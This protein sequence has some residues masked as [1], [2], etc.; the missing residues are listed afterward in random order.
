MMSLYIIQGFV[1]SALIIAVPYLSRG[2]SK[3]DAVRGCSSQCVS[4]EHVSHAASQ[5]TH[6][7]KNVSDISFEMS[8]VVSE[9]CDIN[10]KGLSVCAHTHHVT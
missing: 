8:R 10:V 7:A 2:V 4:A 6:K 5:R 9:V 1:D 3:C